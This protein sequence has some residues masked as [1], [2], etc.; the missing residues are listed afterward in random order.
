MS[1]T[2]ILVIEDDPLVR[3]VL[4]EPLTQDSMSCL[5]LLM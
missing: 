2:H 5:L 4:P 3:D 1:E